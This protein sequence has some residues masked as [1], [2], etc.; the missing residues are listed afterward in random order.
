MYHRMKIRFFS[1]YWY[2]MF[3]WYKNNVKLVQIISSYCNKCLFAFSNSIASRDVRL[4]IGCIWE[5]VLTKVRLFFSHRLFLS[6]FR[7]NFLKYS[8]AK[9]HW[10]YKTIWFC[11]VNW[12][13]WTLIVKFFSLFGLFLA[14][15][16]YLV[17]WIS[18]MLWLSVAN[19]RCTTRAGCRCGNMV[20]VCLCR[21]AR[22]TLFENCT[23]IQVLYCLVIIYC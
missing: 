11:L 18:P 23:V 14:C 12:H 21:I 4:L 7:H 8:I 6:I 20:F 13:Y 10:M 16:F 19:G 17:I 15:W 9:Y 3:D 22:T 2:S 5:C 1:S